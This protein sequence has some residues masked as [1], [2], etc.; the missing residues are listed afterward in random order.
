MP[1]DKCFERRLIM[2]A[3]K[4]VQQLGVAW[5]AAGGE[6]SRS[7]EMAEK[8]IHLRR[9]LVGPFANHTARRESGASK[10]SVDF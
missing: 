9:S 4:S 10:N 3:E 7:A 2:L 1:P 6:Q 5:T 8:T